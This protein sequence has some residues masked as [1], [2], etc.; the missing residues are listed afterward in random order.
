MANTRTTIGT[1][2][3]VMSADRDLSGIPQPVTVTC[4]RLD[5]DTAATD[6]TLHTP[7]SNRYAQV[8]GWQHCDSGAHNV[9]VMSGTA[10]EGQKELVTFEFNP[11]S[12]LSSPL[13]SKALIVAELGKSLVVKVSA[14]IQVLVYVIEVATV[15]L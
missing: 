15:R 12:G 5:F 2:S 1:M 14:A 9:T 11:G 13:D 7:A 4:Y 10:G 6:L 8:V 3:G